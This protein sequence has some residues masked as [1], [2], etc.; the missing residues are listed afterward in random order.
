MIRLGNYGINV[1]DKQYEVGKIASRTNAKTGATEEVLTGSGYH[2]KLES[3]LNSVYRRVTA[4][5]V[6]SYDGDLAGALRLIAKRTE[7]FEKLIKAA[8]PDFNGE[9]P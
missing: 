6:K 5:A 9:T 7:E 8:L 3:A 4:D 1:S 2:T